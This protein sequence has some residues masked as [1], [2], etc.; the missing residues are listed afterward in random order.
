MRFDIE[1]AIKAL[2][3]DATRNSLVCY[4]LTTDQKNRLLQGIEK[5]ETLTELNVSFCNY[6]SN[7]TI[8]LAT[9]LEKK[10][11]I[12]KTWF[13]FQSNWNRWCNRSGQI[14]SNK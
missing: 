13:V 1:R 9:A 5:I 8:A 12:D 4:R 2:E 10:Q 14:S 11:E 6:D 3:T 7:D